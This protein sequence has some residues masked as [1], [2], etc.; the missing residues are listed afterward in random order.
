MHSKERF[1]RKPGKFIYFFNLVSLQGNNIHYSITSVLIIFPQWQPIYEELENSKHDIE[2][3]GGTP[4]SQW[5]ENEVEAGS[6]TTIIIDVGYNDAIIYLYILFYCNYYT[7]QD[8]AS[9]LGKD[10]VEMFTVFS[11][12][13]DCNLVF[14][15]HNLFDRHS[16]FRD[17]SLNSKYLVSIYKKVFKL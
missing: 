5:L 7:H 4:D 11:H 10:L 12:H 3:I 1:T 15:A 17:I 6:N 16:G 8:Q 2:F 13:L 14:V 9:Q